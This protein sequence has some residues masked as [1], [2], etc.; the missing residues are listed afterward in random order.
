[1][2]KTSPKIAFGLYALEIK[3]DSTLACSSEQTFSKVADLKTNFVST[4]PIVTYEPDYWVLDGNYKFKSTVDASTHV[5][6]FSLVMSDASGDFAVAPILTITFGS[7][8]SSDGLVLRFAQQS[9][10]FANDIDVAYY[11]ASNVL[12]RTDNYNPAGWEFSTTQAVTDFKK[13]IITFNSTN[14]PYRYLRLT[15]VDFGELVYFTG[16]DIKQATLIQECN[17]LSV[18]VPIDTLDINLFSSD[19][20]FSIISPS[21]DYEKLKENLPLD[22]YEQIENETIY[23]G[24]FYLDTWKNVSNNEIVFHCIDML[25]VLDKIP[26]LYG[27]L[28][29]VSDG[30]LL[31]PTTAAILISDVLGMI[32]TPYYIDPELSSIEI[33]GWIPPCSYREA[34]QIIAFSIGARVTCSRMGVIQFYK[35]VIA[36]DL[37]EFDHLI[38]YAKKGMNQSLELAPLVTGIELISHKYYYEE[39]SASKFVIFDGYL[40]EGNYTFKTNYPCLNIGADGSTASVDFNEVGVNFVEVEITTAGNL[41]LQANRFFDTT[42]IFSIHNTGLD[43]SIRKNVIKIDCT[44]INENNVEELTQKI[45]DYYQ[46]R[47]LQDVKLYASKISSGDSVLVDTLYNNQIGGVVEKAV[48]DLS[49]GFTS[50]VT[51]RGAI[52]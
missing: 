52:I 43:A 42:R 39:T 8:H 24:K 34:L 15:G 18:E 2:S 28:S 9:A 46:M 4:S 23:L 20:S 35:S 30:N 13:I 25:G 17:P 3:P 21:G 51:I 10:D 19:A 32:N 12:I 45:Y 48:F 47:Y 40:P 33:T 37:L 31:Y 5:G 7:V 50:K 6:L 27:G 16:T 49:G 29:S 44:L 11:N 1:M 41:H 38:T 14:N 22:A 26:Y 36:S